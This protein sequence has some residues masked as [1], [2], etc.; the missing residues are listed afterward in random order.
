MIIM[1]FQDADTVLEPSQSGTT[2][3]KVSIK[4]WK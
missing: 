2:C 4:K 3:D 1:C